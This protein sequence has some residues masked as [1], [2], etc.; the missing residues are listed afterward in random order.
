[1][2]PTKDTYT[3]LDRAY[4]YF[5]KA[6]FASQLPGCLITMARHK[7][8]YGYFWGGTWTDANQTAVTDEIA[9]NPDHLRDRSTAESLSTLVHEMC[10]LKQHHFGK[11][12]RSGYH[13]KEWALMMEEVGLIPS[14]TG[15]PGG[16]K[17]GQKVS[18]YI[19]P[20]GPFDVICGAFIESGFEIPWI[21]LT[22][23]DEELRKKKAASKTKYT[24]SACGVNA[25]AKPDTALICGECE[26][27]M[28]PE[29]AEL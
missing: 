19:E 3:E 5:N 12:S 24:C 17:T 26:E 1:M 16:K 4:G 10:H 18:H 14:S 29:I 25:W 11:P 7:K 9:L 20:R 28:E 27:V 13:N 8:A 6:L 22:G 2:K 15:E 21:A 23:G